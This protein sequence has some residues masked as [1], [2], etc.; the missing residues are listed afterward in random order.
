MPHS[1]V[2]ADAREFRELVKGAIKRTLD[3]LEVKAAAAAKEK[4]SVHAGKAPADPVTVA[5]RE[6]DAQLREL[7]DQAHG[8]N[9]DLGHA[10]V[11]NL[12]TV[13]PADIDVA[14]FLVYGLLGPETAHYLGTGDHVARTIAANGIRLVLDEQRTT[15]TPTL[16]SGQPGKTKVTYGEPEDALKWLWRFVLCRAAGYAESAFGGLGL[17]CTAGVVVVSRSG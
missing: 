13:D 4:K 2:P 1:D 8:A 5:K 9:L 15:E 14:R 6:R 11:H 17:R 10:L 16:K 12:T 3:D 7:T